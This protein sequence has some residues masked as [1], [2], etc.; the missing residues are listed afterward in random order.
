MA[1]DAQSDSAQTGADTTRRLRCWLR[2]AWIAFVVCLFLPGCH[3]YSGN[4]ITIDHSFPVGLMLVAALL[5]KGLLEWL[6]ASSTIAFLLTPLAPAL[7]VA[8]SAIARWGLLALQYWLLSIWL[9]FFI[10]WGHRPDP[11]V[12][13][14]Y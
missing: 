14:R 12:S 8:N 6:W 11:T 3:A 13:L 4:T 10:R 7:A 1:S 9:L 5:G 2:P